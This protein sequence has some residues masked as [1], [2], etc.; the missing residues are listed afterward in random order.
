MVERGPGH[1]WAM[2]GAYL[3]LTAL[4]IF[5]HL[6]PLQTL[7]RQFAGPDLLVALT[8]AWSLRRPDY[9]PALL[10]A[11]VMLLADLLFGRPP[12]LWALTIL[13]GAEWLKRRDRRMRDTTFVAEWL[14]VAT[15][16]FV[17][18]LAYRLTLGI[19]IVPAGAL[20]LYITQYIMTVL[21]YPLVVG[22]SHVL[23]RV[24]RSAPGEV[25]PMGRSL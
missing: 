17:L 9:V 21:A 14:T 20:F 4:V 6:L 25:D 13:I 2:R 22:L 7:P 10:I 18:T 19:L 8:F 11:G 5:L 3:A 12:G 15:L 23:F 24:R 16:L 1:I